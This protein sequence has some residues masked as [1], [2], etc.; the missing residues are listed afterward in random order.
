MK[1]QKTLIYQFLKND[2]SLLIV[3]DACRYDYFV[4]YSYLLGCDL[5]I[6][7]V[8]SSGSCTIEWLKKTFTRP[9]KDVVYIAANPF[10]Y[11]F[12][13]QFGNVV[14]LWLHKWDENLGTVRAEV[15]SKSVKRQ[16]LF[17]PNRKVIAHFL[18]PHAPFVTGSWLNMSYD[19]S[20]RKG[21]RL[22][23]YELSERSFEAR[24]EFIRAYIE[25]VKYVLAE[26]GTL[27]KWFNKHFPHVKIII[28][29]DHGESLGRWDPLYNFR[30]RI[31]KWIPYI[32]GIYRVVGHPCNKKYP[33]LVYVPWAIVGLSTVSRL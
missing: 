10:I 19:D 31:W 25:N 7:K 9:L 21:V 15:V 27:I 20:I 12:T 28:T 16:F 22:R 23:A 18:Q 32:L 13:Q 11:K 14:H 24:R 2:G 8:R 30:K 33:E 29:S 1:P 6:E 5:K 3:L 4:K 17:N 26:L